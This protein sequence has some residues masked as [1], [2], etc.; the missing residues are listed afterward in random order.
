[1]RYKEYGYRY[2]AGGTDGH[3]YTE[4]LTTPCRGVSGSQLVTL[5]RTAGM[6]HDVFPDVARQCDCG[7]E[8]QFDSGLGSIEPCWPC[9]VDWHLQALNVGARRSRCAYA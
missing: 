8:S 6:T 9:W 1:M 4:R 3:Q 5:S 7:E 2:L